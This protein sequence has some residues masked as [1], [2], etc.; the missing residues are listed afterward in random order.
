MWHLWSLVKTFG[1][2]YFRKK[3]IKFSPALDWIPCK[4]ASQPHSTNRHPAALTTGPI[5]KCYNFQQLSSCIQN[6]LRKIRK[7]L[8]QN[9]TIY[10][11]NKKEEK[12]G[13]KIVPRKILNLMHIAGIFT[14]RNL[15]SNIKIMSNVVQVKS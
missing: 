6:L 15:R 4:P 11:K 7:K 14:K 1:L 5:V 3:R 13:E 8:P 12:F 9:A 2:V 10:Q